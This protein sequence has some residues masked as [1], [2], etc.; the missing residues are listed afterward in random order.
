[1]ISEDEIHEKIPGIPLG[2]DVDVWILCMTKAER[3]RRRIL[4]IAI[5]GPITAAI[6]A[7][8]AA[9]KAISWVWG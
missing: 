2:L 7:Y 1:M 4:Y 6:S 5:N 9:L 3:N 8:N